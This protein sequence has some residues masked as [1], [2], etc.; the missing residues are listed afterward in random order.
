M[1]NEKDSMHFDN[2][3]S[4]LNYFNP[5]FTLS[6]IIIYQEFINVQH[7]WKIYYKKDLYAR[8][9][10]RIP[11]YIPTWKVYDTNQLI[12]N[13]PCE[14][15]RV[16]PIIPP[17]GY[18]VTKNTKIKYL[19]PYPDFIN[20]VDRYIGRLDDTGRFENPGAYLIN[21][22]RQNDYSDGI[23][24]F[25]EENFELFDGDITEMYGE[26]VAIYKLTI[27][28]LRDRYMDIIMKEIGE[29]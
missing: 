27:E 17:D 8:Y 28:E 23:T 16:N 24:E 21:W 7:K 10:H 9:N 11:A 25:Y 6:N 4:A 13:L 22:F 12:D 18:K 19:E 26:F 29:V 3:E 2:I 1:S 20:Y 14:I 15:E 5:L